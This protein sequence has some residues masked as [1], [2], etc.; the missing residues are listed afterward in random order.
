MRQI[1]RIHYNGCDVPCGQDDCPRIFSSFSAL[2]NHFKKDHSRLLQ[3]VLEVAS[4]P[5]TCLTV[6]QAANNLASC[7][8]NADIDFDERSMMTEDSSLA[9]TSLSDLPSSIMQFVTKLSAQPNV[10]LSNVNSTITDFH[11]LLGNVSQFCVHTVKSMCQNLGV[12]IATPVVVNAIHQIEGMSQLVNSVNTEY[13]RLK[14]LKRNSFYIDPQEMVLG[15]RRESRFDSKL[16]FTKV[17]IVQDTMQYVPIEKLLAIM[18]NDSKACTLMAEQREYSQTLGNDCVNDFMSTDYYR[19]HPFYSKYPDAFIIHLYIDAF[20]TT[21]ELGSHTQ[22]HKLEGLYMVVRNFPARYLSKLNTIF[23]LGLWYAHDVKTYGYDK[24]MRPIVD[25]LKM[26]ETDVGVRVNV[27]GKSVTVRGILSLFSADN[28]G[29]HS[30]F[31]F[32]ESFSAI[33]FCH[34][35]ECTKETSQKNF[36]ESQFVMRTKD[37]YDNAVAKLDDPECNPSSTGIKR[38]CI[39]NELTYF[40]VVENN[41]VDAMHD[42]LEGIVPLKFLLFWTRW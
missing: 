36:I 42:L 7:N 17:V 14:Y 6:S 32:L 21:N 4:V 20:E 31:G 34:F 39:L 35:C 38:G 12:N 30:L 15:N 26:L 2:K 24:L 1:H 22:V 19:N 9:R 8:A 23:L 29:L 18:L 33:K 11:E 25:A 40:H 16:G 13:K 27:N 41:S 37:S 28:L 10:L 5:T 3:N